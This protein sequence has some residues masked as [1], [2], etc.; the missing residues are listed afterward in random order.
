MRVG[1]LLAA[2]LRLGE[3]VIGALCVGSSRENAFSVEE[4]FMLTRLANSAAIA[5]ENARLYAQ[6][7][8]LA[9]MEERQRIAAEMHDGLAQTL[10]YLRLTCHLAQMKI[11]Q[12]E[13]APAQEV[14]GKVQQALDRAESETRRAIASLE[15]NL[16]LHFTLQEQLESLVDEFNQRHRGVRWQT[17]LAVP[18]LISPHEAE[19]V[20]R[21]AR[22]ALQNACH[23][24]GANVITLSLE[25]I[26]GHAQV[27]IVDDG[28]GFDPD[29]VAPDEDRGHFGLKIMRARA[30]RLGGELEVRSAAGQGTQVR[31]IW[32]LVRQGEDQ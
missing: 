6:A 4:Q 19:Q 27:V 26:D 9:T 13:I 24:S 29:G 2:P 3:R 12:G 32:P 10:N 17:N 22:E 14:L 15:E 16:P 21:V 7:E 23:H 1:S 31:L 11:E 8:Q 5:L 25:G 20:L 28:H 30:A 18:L